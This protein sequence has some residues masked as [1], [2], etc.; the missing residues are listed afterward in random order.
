MP[1][2]SVPA[3]N[4]VGLKLA[5]SRGKPETAGVWKEEQRQIKFDYGNKREGHIWD[6]TC[7]ITSCKP[8]RPGLLSLPH[9][10][11]LKAGGHEP[12]EAARA[13]FEDMPDYVDLS[14]PFED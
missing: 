8:G 12:W 13:M 9:G 1:V 4:F 14:A 3:T 7:I 5:L 6:D 11:F 10:D 2:S